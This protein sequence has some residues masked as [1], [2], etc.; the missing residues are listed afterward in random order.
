MQTKLRTYEISP[1]NNICFPIGT[2]L[3][4]QIQHEKLGFQY[5][6]SK[7]KKK[8]RDLNSLI[9]ALVTHLRQFKIKTIAIDHL[10]FRV[11][12]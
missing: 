8:G 10:H 3:T 1:N 11:C 4:V 2:I 12:S 6:F 9:T 7:Y 5:V